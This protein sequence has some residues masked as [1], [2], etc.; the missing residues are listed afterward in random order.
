MSR[1]RPRAVLLALLLALA[2]VAGCASVPDS[3]PVQVLRRVTGGDTPVLPPGPVEGSNPADLVRGFV[4]A[5]GSS[6][7]RHGAARRF[8]APEAA[9]WDDGA[10]VTVLD[11]LFNTVYP[12]D[13]PGP[14]DETTTVRIRGTAIGRLGADGA[15]RPEQFPVE[16]DVTLVRR[17]DQW[18]I[19]AVPDGVLVPLSDFRAGYRAVKVYFV[20]PVSRN[21]VADL[22]YVPADPTGAQAAR[23]MELLLAGPSAALVG[24][25]VSRLPAEARLR[26][27]VAE[28]PDGSLVVD[29]TQLGDVDVPARRLLAAQV[30]LTLA[31]VNVGRVRLLVDGTPLLPDLPDVTREDL[32]ALRAEV[33]PAADVPGLV[34]A[35]G[36]VSRLSGPQQGEPLPGPAGNGGVDVESAASTVDGRRLAVVAREGG[37]RRLLVGGGGDG[38]VAPVDLAAGT[39]TR[40]SWTPSGSEA[41]TVLDGTVVARVLADDAV[42]APRTEQVDAAQLAAIGPIRRLRLSR[43]GLRVAAVVDGGLYTAAVARTID[44]EVAIRNV[45]RI[46]PAELGEVVD[47]DWRTADSLVAITGRADRPVSLVSADGL[48]LQSVPPSNL[49]PPLTA[50]A[51]VGSRPLL[52]AD[53]AGVWSFAGGELD[54]WRQV[55]GGV[56][57]AVPVYPG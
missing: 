14:G 32:A 3:S 18:R 26:S 36:R 2:A 12:R 38:G 4:N 40:P 46:R 39:M 28:G 52:V 37:T 7:D 16:V 15:F 6:V 27:N 1:R 5:S 35:G 47:V 22:R 30:V 31:D 24:A 8:L 55:L 19:S 42:G 23:A 21:V 54:A 29:L 45:R 25:A 17:D 50:V 48:T 44:G 41:W 20:D 9:D 56:P 43:D 49:T 53:R 13:L 10:G 57:D 51:A 34:V 11:G 33:R